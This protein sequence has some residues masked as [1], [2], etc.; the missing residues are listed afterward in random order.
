[1]NAHDDGL[2]CN[3]SGNDHFDTIVTRRWSRRDVL[4]GGA[5]M[6][7]L[8]SGSALLAACGQDSDGTGAAGAE[9]SAF[10][11]MPAPASP[12]ALGF[13]PVAK[14]L[15]D[16]VSVPPGYTAQ[17][18]YR[19]GDSINAG[20]PNYRNDG[21]D[22]SAS[23]AFRA[24]DHHDG[25]HF[26][27]MAANGGFHARES[28]R[29]LLAMNHEAIT[30]AY[31]H[32]TGQTI[33]AGA[34]TVAEEVQR[35]FFVHGVSIVEAQRAGTAWSINR[36]GV[37]NRRIH[38]L[39]DMELSGPAARHASMI[40]K[41]SPDGSRT[42]GTVNNCANGHTPWGTYLT[43]EENW[44]GYFRRITATDNPNRTPKELA[45]FA[46]YGVGGN[47]RELWAT[48]TPDTPDNQYGRWNAMKLGTS[49]DGRDDYRNAANTY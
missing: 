49:A 2:D 36:A 9:R 12:P 48:V 24:G 32:P 10:D 3:V 43:C 4:K 31:L 46:R 34:R 47:G 19:L 1:M 38:T 44:A 7:A 22:A 20:I 5:G 15:A 45:S 11:P 21:T 30:P 29:G 25:M 18:L 17:V 28:N 42:R 33:V 8:L 37:Y 23:F 13:A 27:G 26:F 41:Y 40:T 14:N 39:T 6:G 16:A 35:E